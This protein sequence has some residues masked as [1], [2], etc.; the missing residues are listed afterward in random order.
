[1]TYPIKTELELIQEAWEV[2]DA[3]NLSGVV[4]S[5]SR[6][7]TRLWEIYQDRAKTTDFRFSSTDIN[8]HIISKL[9]ASKIMSLS[10]DLP[11]DLS[12]Y[13]ITFKR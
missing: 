10:G 13:G 6:A 8:Q 2:Q 3:C 4:H 12:S 1:M 7:M 5:F 9:Y 11:I